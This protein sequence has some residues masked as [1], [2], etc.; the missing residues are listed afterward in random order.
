MQERRQRN[1]SGAMTRSRLAVLAGGGGLVL[2][3]LLFVEVV[4]GLGPDNDLL[5]S[6]DFREIFTYQKAYYREALLAGRLPLWNPHSFAGWPFAANAIAQVFYPPSLLY[7]PFSQATA[8]ALDLVLHLLIGALGAYLLLRGS[9]RLSRDSAAFGGLTYA[10]AGVFVGHAYAGHPPF[11]AAAVYT[12]FL[13]YAADRCSAHLASGKPPAVGSSFSLA[14]MLSR[15]GPFLWTG[16]LILGLQIL[17]GGL[18]FVWLGM[19]LVGCYRAGDVLCRTPL[20]L[21]AWRRE[22]LVLGVLTLVG[23]ALGAIQ[24]VPSYELASLSNRF[25]TGYEYAATGSYD[26]KL[27][28]TLLFSHARVEGQSFLWEYYGYVG[29]L[30]VLLAGLSLTQIRR[31]PRVAALAGTTLLILLFMIGDHGPLFPV[32]WR[33]VPTFDL[34]RAPA[35]A[36]VNLDLILALLAALGLSLVARRLPGTSGALR[37]A[38]VALSVLVCAVTWGDVTLAARTNR[39]GMLLPDSGILDRASHRRLTRLL[40][41][42]RSWHR[43][44]FPRAVFRQN[45]A[46]HARARSIGGYDNLYLQRYS[47]FVHHMTDTRIKPSLP[48]ILTQQTFVNAPSAFPFKILGVRYA[49]RGRGVRVREPADSVRRAWFTTRVRIVD[50]EAAALDWMRSDRFAPF[51]EVVFE[52]PEASALDLSESTPPPGR[53]APPAAPVEIEV[54]ELSPERLRV[55]LGPHPDGFLVLSEIFY[56]GWDARIDGRDVPVVRADSI[57]RSI[58][59]RQGARVVELVYDPASL[60]VGAWTSGCALLLSCSGLLAC[61]TR[62][63]ARTAIRAETARADRSAG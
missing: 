21:T 31:N 14:A 36:L 24:L 52:A 60:R 2:A 3:V 5:M 56:P 17:S 16:A 6:Y 30:P 1:G 44:W 53:K 22:A 50:D 12:P 37:H 10:L 48:T 9:F 27:L 4:Y 32:L 29:V 51:G 18:P 61:W 7:L 34:F 43:Y 35:R 41:K 28:P 33:Y 59:L 63:R 40:E 46:F 26:P 25:A 13:M 55:H 20:N 54:E 19:L 42:E 38:T 57:L 23:T 15:A 47:R 39:E 58:P 11:Y 49:S 62:R 45:H 8:A